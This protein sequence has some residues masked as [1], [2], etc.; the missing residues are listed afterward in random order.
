MMPER[1]VM[2]AAAWRLYESHGSGQRHPA[3]VCW[4]C[5]EALGTIETHGVTDEWTTDRGPSRCMLVI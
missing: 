5:R 4:A 1:D 2:L 3:A